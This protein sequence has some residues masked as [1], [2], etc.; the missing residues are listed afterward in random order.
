MD[1]TNETIDKYEQTLVSLSP[2]LITGDYKSKPK[3]RKNSKKRRVK[4]RSPR[5]KFRDNLKKT[6]RKKHTKS[7]ERINLKDL[8]TKVSKNQTRMKNGLKF[9]KEKKTMKI[10]KKKKNQNF[11]FGEKFKFEKK[12]EKNNSNLSR[13]RSIRDK[14]YLD[15]YRTKK[16]NKSKNSK[17]SEEKKIEKK[18]KKQNQVKSHFLLPVNKQKKYTNYSSI[19]IKNDFLKSRSRSTSKFHSSSSQNG[20]KKVSSIIEDKDSI[21]VSDEDTISMIDKQSQG[22]ILN[23][24]NRKKFSRKNFRKNSKTQAQ[25]QDNLRK[26]CFKRK[27]GLCRKNKKV[28]NLKK[29]KSENFLNQTNKLSTTS[30]LAVFLKDKLKKP[31][32]EETR[33]AMKKLKKFKKMTEFTSE[34]NT[35]LQLT[36]ISDDLDSTEGLVRLLNQNMKTQESPNSLI[37][38]KDSFFQTKQNYSKLKK[39]INFSFKQNENMNSRSNSESIERNKFRNIDSK[40]RAILDQIKVV[41]R[42]CSKDGF[43]QETKKSA[44]DLFGS[45]KD[46]FDGIGKEKKELKKNENFNTK[47]LKKIK[48]EERKNIRDR[49]KA[50][51]ASSKERIKIVEIDEKSK[52][53]FRKTN[54]IKSI[55]PPNS[56]L[57]FSSKRKLGFVSGK[58]R[59]N[60]L[61]IKASENSSLRTD[62]NSIR[63]S[64]HQSPRF[65]GFKNRYYM[66]NLKEYV[67]KSKGGYFGRLFREHLR[68]GFFSLKLLKDEI[69]MTPE[70]VKYLPKSKFFFQFFFQF[71]F[72]KFL[73]DNPSRKTLVIDLDETLVHCFTKDKIQCQRVIRIPQING[74]I[75]EVTS[76]KNLI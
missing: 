54:S 17:K 41:G 72:L 12:I 16:L 44:L 59:R 74:S 34:E 51:M 14:K 64:R 2:I 18:L 55:T 38:T 65:K 57:R 28:G 60:F 62:Q 52:K 21:A 24:K 58:K 3:R 33:R 69:M 6:K 31:K 61:S 19:K 71:F 7:A 25:S 23:K 15:L 22:S 9:S 73:G 53:K 11:S 46:N 35:K 10:T 1:I 49:K 13:S 76:F 4:S 29:I 48:K 75:L 70:K 8:L 30:P 27:N 47:I 56:N 39:E 40:I 45:S 32:C 50:F 43:F 67:S 68:Q 66:K 63:S 36:V 37:L 20:K 26:K 42:S 5:N